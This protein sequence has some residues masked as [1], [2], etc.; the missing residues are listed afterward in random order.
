MRKVLVLGWYGTETIGDLAI[1]LG[2]TSDYRAREAVS[3]VVPSQNPGYTRH[4]LARIGLDATV[5]SYGDRELLGELW[6]CDTV[7]VGGGPLMDIPQIT[8]LAA[9]VERARRLGRHIVIEGCGVGPVVLEST[10]SAIRRLVEASDVIRLRDRGSE[11]ALKALGID[12]SVQVVDDPGWRWVRSTGVV[13]AP[14]GDAPIRLFLR[15]LTWEYPQATSSEKVTTGLVALVS[16]ICDVAE[17]RA[18]WL[19]AMHHFPIGGDD[20]IYARRIAA[21]VGREHCH[22]D[23]VPR[24]PI[25]TVRLMASAAWVVCMRF[26]SLV[27]AHAVGAPVLAIDYT[28]GGKVSHFAH[29]HGLD[30]LLVAVDALDNV[31]PRTALRHALLATATRRLTL[32]PGAVI[33]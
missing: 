28:N 2:I 1:L 11:R 24:T 32:A 15:E 14:D 16:R 5:T 31:D 12:R 6:G 20:R 27:F 33:G 4:N 7:I 18:V 25:E 21:Q 9:V 8:L 3:F 29:E 30:R 13:H 19:H 10:R 22:V 17:G 23:M 26:H